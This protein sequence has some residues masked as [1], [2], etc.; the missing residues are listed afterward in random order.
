M[1]ASLYNY[2]NINLDLQLNLQHK[3]NEFST[4]LK[5]LLQKRFFILKLRFY[6]I[7]R[8]INFKTKNLNITLN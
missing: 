7:L 1:V 4:N 8:I 2:I 6:C 5:L 3:K